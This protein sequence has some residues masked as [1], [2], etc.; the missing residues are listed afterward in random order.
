[1][2]AAAG[3]QSN[4]AIARRLAITEDTVRSSRRFLA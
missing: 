4:A 1:V 2:L 3:G